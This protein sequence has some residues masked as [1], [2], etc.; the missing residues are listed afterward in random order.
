MDLQGQVA[1]V[2]GGAIRVGRAISLAL[3]E[4]G[5][6]IVLNY[7][8]SAQAAEATAA[9]IRARGRRVLPCQADVSQVDQVEAMVRASIECFG[10][11]DILVNSASPWQATPLATVDEA[12]WDMVI[13]TN[14]KGPFFLTRAAAPYLAAH[15]RGAVVNI[16]DLSSQVP[17]PNF[18]AHSV[19]KAGLLNMTY[20][21]AIELAPAVRVNAI[22]PGPVLPPPE[23]TPEHIAATAARTLAGRWGS[24]EDVAN[25]VLYLVQAPYVT[26]VFLP[27]DGG[28][29]LGGRV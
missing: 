1:L 29:R 14:L 17:F 7:R 23:Y 16:V 10:R 3:A 22:A 25:A 4:A 26:G 24:A 8:S 27:V 2:T 12:T 21:L 15:G 18:L 28:E 19:A 13:D 20:A 5:A 6:N 9:E 11:L